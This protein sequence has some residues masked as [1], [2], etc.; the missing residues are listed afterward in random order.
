MW[1]IF[2]EMYLAFTNMCR[3]KQINFDTIEGKEM[4][5]NGDTP[6]AQYVRDLLKQGNVVQIEK[7][8]CVRGGKK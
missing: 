5:L 6:E 3:R 8:S 7:S 4:D 2:R 1:V